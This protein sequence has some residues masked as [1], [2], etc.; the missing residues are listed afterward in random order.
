MGASTER[1]LR[2]RCVHC[3]DAIAV[4]EPM[5]FETESGRIGRS[6]LSEPQREVYVR[7]YH[8][9]CYLNRA[10]ASTRLRPASD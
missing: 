7:L 5:I 8:P 6:S 4:H 3:L 10:M 1:T 9:D 2:E